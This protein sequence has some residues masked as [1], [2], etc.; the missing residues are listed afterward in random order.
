MAEE[1][2]VKVNQLKKEDPVASGTGFVEAVYNMEVT[3]SYSDLVKFITYFESKR[4]PIYFTKV[5]I[6]PLSDDASDLK[7]SL[8]MI[9][10]GIDTEERKL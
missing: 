7:T 2:N 1:G 10:Y 6:E 8:R 4:S 9:A 5:Q 3:S